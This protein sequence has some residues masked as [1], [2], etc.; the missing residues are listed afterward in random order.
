MT[1]GLS[2]RRIASFCAVFAA[3]V[4]VSTA[5][6]AP[7]NGT[8]RIVSAC[9]AKVMEVLGGSTSNNARAV[10][11]AWEN[12]DHQKWRLERLADGTYR[13]V[14]VHSGKVLD[15]S[16]SVRQDGVPVFQ[17]YAWQDATSQRFTF[18]DAGSGYWR[19]TVKRYG[20]H[21]TVRYGSSA[22]GTTVWQRPLASD[23]SQKWKFERLDVVKGTPVAAIA[24]AGDKQTAVIGTRVA[25]A[26]AIKVLDPSGLPVA[27]WS[28]VF[29]V[30]SGGGSVSGGSATTDSQG[31]ARVGS[32]TLGSVIGTQKLAGAAQGLPEVVFS[33]NA[34]APNGSGTLAPVAG[35]NNQTAVINTPLDV[36]LQ[37]TVRD[38]AGR[39]RSGVN[40]LFSVLSGGGWLQYTS[41]TSDSRGIASAGRWTLGSTLGTQTVRASASGH[42]AVDF[43][44]T[45]LAL[46]APSLTREVL[47]RSVYELWDMAFTP[48]GAMLFTE[49]GRGLSVR[50]SNGTVRR[51]FAPADLVSED[52]SGMLGVAIDPAFS[53]NRRVYVYMASNRSGVRDNRVIRVRVASDYTSVSDRADIVTGIS[54]QR[55]TEYGGRHSGGDV[56][57]GADGYLYVTTGDTRT[58]TV[59]QSLTELGGKVLRVDTN[60]YAAPGNNAPAGANPRIYSY[61][62]RNP[63][64]L[65]MRPGGGVYLIEHGPTY[66]D[67]VTRLR[68][69]GNGGWDPRPRPLGSSTATCANGVKL[70]YCGYQG[71]RMTDTTLYPS[72]MLPVWRSGSPARGTGGGDFLVGSAWKG[73]NG[74]LAVAQMS[75]RRLLVLQLDSTGT[76]VVAQTPLLNTLNYRIR[77]AVLG[78]DGALYLSTSSDNNENQIV[79]TELWRLA[80]R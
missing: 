27:N 16:S 25:V 9:G 5:H 63:Q 65:A 47:M 6:A 38:S 64:G 31:I 20:T 19:L 50:F 28:V 2:A 59:P 42:V 34:T 15:A 72:A 18:A 80:P 57:F 67:E 17:Q 69:G 21:L 51:I 40:V 39:V 24:V 22:D 52:Q 70:E 32:W 11:W 26:P 41:V 43:I 7:A 77:N 53:S 23:C 3:F 68:A 76:R 74:A 61:G 79:A 33:A 45:G 44:A 60:G 55:G 62:F 37:V 66:D 35:S 10:L 4:S 12:E 14:A 49:R 58:G 8:Y 78:R 75:G 29:R 56:D 30:V 71:S 36:P 13:L 54:F 48:D 73:W 1:L 46:S